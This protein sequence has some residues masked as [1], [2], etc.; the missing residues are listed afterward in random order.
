MYE[1]QGK[2]YADWRDRKGTRKR[3]SFTTARAALRFESEQKEISHPKFKAQG[4]PLPKL[5]A[6]ASKSQT[7]HAPRTPLSPKRSS[8]KLAHSS[9]KR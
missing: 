3:K 1:K 8:L 7:G 9:P 4:Q 5:S 2:F 6:P